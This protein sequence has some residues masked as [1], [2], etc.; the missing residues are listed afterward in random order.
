M[1]GD[2]K[3]IEWMREWTMES[4]TEQFDYR[5]SRQSEK[6]EHGHEAIEP[7]MEQ[8]NQM[9]MYVKRVVR[10]STQRAES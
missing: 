6:G 5:S 3:C 9:L 10:Q 4:V 2:R 7:A 8:L 1:L